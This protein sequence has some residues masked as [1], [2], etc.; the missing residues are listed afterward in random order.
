LSLNAVYL[1]LALVGAA[2][3]AGLFWRR[4]QGRAR[5]VGA[6][7]AQIIRPSDLGLADI[8][9][10]HVDVAHVAGAERMPFGERATLVQFSTEYCASCPG[11]RRMLKAVA[12]GYDGVEHV[13]V[14]LTHRGDLANTYRILQTPTTFILDGA[15]TLVARIGGSARRDVVHAQLD[16]IAGVL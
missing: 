16:S 14:D 11:T 13:D 2:T 15:G 1:V 9:L 5:V 8:S 10:E 6:T 3:I 12:A 4:A 7:A